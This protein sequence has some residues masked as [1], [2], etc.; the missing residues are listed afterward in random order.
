MIP[1]RITVPAMNMRFLITFFLVASTLSAPLKSQTCLAH[2]LLQE[3]MESDEQVAASRDRIESFTQNWIANHAAETQVTPRNVLTIPVVVHVVW[4]TEAENISDAQIV[5]QIEALNNDY[6][7]LNANAGIVTFP[8]FLSVRADSEIQFELAIMDPAGNATNGI[9]RTQTSLEDIGLLRI[10]GKR[11]ICYDDLGGKSV[12]CSNHYLNIWVGKFPQGITGEAS[13]PGQDD[14]EE[15]G[16]R[17]DADHF[18]TTGTVAPPYHLGR[19]ATHEVGHYLN[20]Y[21]IWGGSGDSDPDCEF[22]DEVPDTPNQAFNYK[23]QC[24]VW[25]GQISCGPLPDMFYNYMDYTND[26]CMAMFTLGQKQRM[27]ATLNGPRA[28]LLTQEGLCKPITGTNDFADAPKLKILPNPANQYFMME[29]T[30]G[31]DLVQCFDVKG[32][33]WPVYQEL[34]DRFSVAH[35]PAGTYIIQV[36]NEKNIITKKLIIARL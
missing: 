12:W 17:I 27:R 8:P 20:L 28:E 16:V 9:T 23:G 4:R 33:L 35:L 1:D 31:A 7:L 32:T 3:R 21:H 24:P 2:T 25:S 15:D 18:G 13:F 34:G 29:G 36:K 30:Q 6:R 14:P 22:D 11:A 5:S 10:G 19:T 26:A